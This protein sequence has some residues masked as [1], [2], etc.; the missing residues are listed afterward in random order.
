M[1]NDVNYYKKLNY[2]QNYIIGTYYEKE[3]YCYFN[4]ILIFDYESLNVPNWIA[5]EVVDI[6]L[7]ILINEDEEFQLIPTSISILLVKDI[8]MDFIKSQ[9]LLIKKS[10]LLSPLLINKNHWVLIL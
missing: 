8:C 10:K 2:K 9:S 5:N 4:K 6:C 7:N 1:I 3:K